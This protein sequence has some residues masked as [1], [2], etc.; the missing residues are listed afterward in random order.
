MTVK[1]IVTS[2][3]CCIIVSSVFLPIITVNV[4]AET[5]T[6]ESRIMVSLGDSYSSGEGIEPFYGQNES[7]A[8]KVKNQDWLA[9]RSEKSWPGRLTLQG[10]NGSMA[11]NRNDNWFFVATSGAVTDNLTHNQRKE[12]DI[13]GIEGSRYIDKQ[14]DVFKE[15]GDKKAEYVTVS[16]GGNDAKFADIITEAAIP[17]PLNPGALND[18]LNSVWEE[19]YYGIDGGES[20]RDRLYQAYCD[21]QDAA[22]A[23]AKIIVAGYPKLLD[24]NGSGFLFSENEAALINDSVSRFNDEIESIVKSCKADGMKICF[25]SVEKA[26]DGHGAY[27]NDAFLNEVYIGKKDQDLKWSVSS[28]YSM[29]PNDKGAQAYADCV[30][31]KIDEIEKDNGKTEWPLM[32]GSDERD[33]ALVLDVSGSMGGTPMNETKNASERFINTVLKED[34]SIGVVT[35]DNTS[36]C[37]ADFCMNERYLKNAIQ[38]LNSGGG[39]NME[40]GLSQAYSMLQ[41]SDAKKK[42]IVLMSDGEP[43]EGKTGNELIEFAETIKNEGIYIYTLGFFSNSHDKTSPQALLENIASEGCHFEVEN[44]DDL[45]FFFGDIA[46]QI[47]GQKYIYIRIACPVDVTVTYDGETLCSIEENLNTRT[48]FGSLTFEDNEKRTDSSSDNRVKILRL[49]EGTDYDIQIEG[50]GNGYMDYT[51]RFMDDTGEYTDLRKFSDIKITE[52]TVIDTVATNS[53]ATIL[54]VDENGDG[55][56]DLKYKATENAEGELVNDT[57][58]IY[59]YIAVGVVAFILV[60][61][62]IILIMKHLKSKKSKL[63]NR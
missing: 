23:Q 36:M 42:I 3:L 62:A 58:L 53:D 52:Q 26:F 18:K 34:S 45:I 63:E 20:I 15:L 40:A 25:V 41:N 31:A 5:A 1:K 57:Y 49:K 17:H 33:I 28:A 11:Q 24:S 19:F 56:Y 29:H 2:L 7:T 46:D 50:N 16:I 51:I 22:G 61:V 10:V 44:A 47:N 38:N 6:E 9:H 37:I 30:Q 54:N 12:Y 39:T 43:N 8:D 14:L 59:I 13:D 48:A 32:S 4:H 21:I 55:K 60:V 35:Y 27:S